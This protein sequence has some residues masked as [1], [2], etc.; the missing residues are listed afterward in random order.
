MDGA[1]ASIP[2]EAPVPPRTAS[3]GCGSLWPA[4]DHHA[5]D[6]WR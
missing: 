6:G 4:A 2:R 1:G 3:A 5:G